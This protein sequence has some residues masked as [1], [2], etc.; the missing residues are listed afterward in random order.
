MGIRIVASSQK[1]TLE[2]HWG[3]QLLRDCVHHVGSLREA[4]LAEQVKVLIQ[5]L[6]VLVWFAE[7]NL[8]Q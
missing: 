6:F 8:S 5:V 2:T 7:P 1:E 3:D 4:G